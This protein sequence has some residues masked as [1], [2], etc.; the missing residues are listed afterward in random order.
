MK[1]KTILASATVATLCTVYLVRLNDSV[2]SAGNTS[3]STGSSFVSNT[4]QGTTA[5]TTDVSDANL[6][7]AL[8]GLK[9]KRSVV[10]ISNA[11]PCN[12]YG[13]KGT[14]IYLPANIF[15]DAKGNAYTGDVRI[16]LEEC[17]D[18]SDML[19]AK[20]STTSNGKL[21]ETAGMVNIKAFGGGKRLQLRD[22][23]QFNIYF[24]KNEEEKND[25]QLF[26]G[27]WLANDI[28][29]WKLEENGQPIDESKIS[30][31]DVKEKSIVRNLRY[32]SEE[33]VSMYASENNDMSEYGDEY[34]L[35]GEYIEEGD[36]SEG[37]WEEGYVQEEFVPEAGQRKLSEDD[38]CFLQI[39]KSYLRRGT[40]VS[41]MD[42]FNWKLTNGQT[43]N[44]WFVS[45][46]NPDIAMLED[47][48]LNGLRTQ[49]TFQVDE[50]GLFK[51]YYISHTS[52]VIEYDRAL[53]DFI[54]TMPGLDLSQLMP[55]Y[56]ADHACLL[57][58]G[59]GVGDSGDGFVQ[60]FKAKH[61]G[62][63]DKPLTDVEASTLDFF[64]FSSSEL[65]WINC[66]RFYEDTEMVD[67]TVQTNSPECTMSMVFTDINSVLKGIPTD[68]GVLFEGVPADRSIKLVGIRAN[69]NN[70][71]MS[72]LASNTSAKKI[73][74][75]EFKPAGIN[76]LQAEFKP[77]TK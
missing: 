34:V 76:A 56:T 21:L 66:D 22:E 14:V 41:E 31:Y 28:I 43:L 69:N 64:V 15:Q 8:K 10:T 17:Y 1:P 61:K 25:F 2:T 30:T 37:D 11:Q 53:A 50:A 42:Y 40:K 39:A 51:S 46:F 52:S 55:K 3:S 9:T 35:E 57:T 32:E 7:L 18:I 38:N 19:A 20:L 70:A 6:D 47:Y 12:V 49:I 72:V 5:M 45:N 36:W 16:E 23:A 71:E 29:N 75:N 48:C 74:M 67:Y 44:Q 33:E 24:P 58:F 59:T 68:G 27:E 65:G 77:R 62:D 26:Y 60:Q 13:E 73:T 63:P 54:S 4:P